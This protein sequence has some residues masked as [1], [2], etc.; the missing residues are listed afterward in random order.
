MKG[1]I[2]YDEIIDETR[3]Y[4]RIKFISSDDAGKLSTDDNMIHS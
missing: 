1:E 2:R 4:K 3:K